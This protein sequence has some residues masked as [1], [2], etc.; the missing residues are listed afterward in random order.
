MIKPEY[1]KHYKIQNPADWIHGS[2]GPKNSEPCE[3]ILSLSEPFYPNGL[4]IN[5]DDLLIHCVIYDLFKKDIPD[6]NISLENIKLPIK[7]TFGVNHT[8]ISFFNNKVELL[9]ELFY[10][11]LISPKTILFYVDGN[12]NE[13]KHL[14]NNINRLK[15][16]YDSLKIHK[17]QVNPI[18]ED[19]SLI[20]NEKAMRP[21]PCKK[22]GA[23]NNTEILAFKPHY[24]DKTNMELCNVP[25]SKFP[26]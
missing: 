20:D 16:K 8:S 2:E 9:D 18:N 25:C 3:I 7:Q 23:T 19:R 24:N 15:F 21:L 13:L 26:G 22:F 1:G 10:N 12:I 14:L 11:A 6:K 4:W 5:F 17:L